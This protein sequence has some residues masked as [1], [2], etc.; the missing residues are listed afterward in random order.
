MEFSK[1]EKLELTVMKN[2]SKE[3]TALQAKGENR[4][5]FNAT[6]L[7]RIA[8]A[9]PTKK[10]A[11]YVLI[12][13]AQKYIYWRWENLNDSSNFQRFSERT[14]SF[15]NQ[16]ALPS[17]VTERFIHTTKGRYG[18]TWMD[19]HV[20]LDYAQWLSSEIKHNILGCFLEF[21][22]IYN[23]KPN[24]QTELIIEVARHHEMEMMAK[25]EYNE[26]ELED[27]TPQQ[28]IKLQS[29]VS[30]RL[31]Q[32]EAT[33]ALKAM[34]CELY[35]AK[36]SS[37]GSYLGKLFGVINN[38]L[39]GLTSAELSEKLGVAK[40]SREDLD[41]STQRSL[42]I[43]ETQITQY[44]EDALEDGYVVGME[45]LLGVAGGIA[46]KTSRDVYFQ[47][48]KRK[49]VIAERLKKNNTKTGA[50]GYYL[51]EANSKENINVVY[52]PLDKDKK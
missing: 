36:G 24:K 17:E 52:T 48:G 41:A 7:W 49:R 33:G 28:R 20:F 11:Q 37:L 3:F 29:K 46:K 26:I 40:A 13:D 45:D 18:S 16:K 6:E 19:D 14:F 47:H 38:N 44:I 27:L 50:R 23:E 15:E 42:T 32:M 30:A 39:Y 21:G 35:G 4:Y 2:L 8:G 9:D 5:F 12:E 22:F 51:V 43:I 10:P 34:V 25:A 1:K 31:K